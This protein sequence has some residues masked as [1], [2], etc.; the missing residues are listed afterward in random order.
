MLDGSE[1][2]HEEAAWGPISTA[3]AEAKR[4]RAE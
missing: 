3:F 2:T 1:K 4:L